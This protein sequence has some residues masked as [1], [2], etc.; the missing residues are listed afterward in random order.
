M[1]NIA[2][3][4]IL[5][6]K[7]RFLL[8]GFAVVLG[9]A[10]MA[11]TLVLTDTI[12]K[13]F[14]DLFAEANEGT[15]AFVRGRSD[16]EDQFGAA[17]RGQI[18]A[19]LVDEIRQIPGVAGAEGQ[20]Q[21]FALI[22]GAD[23]E[24]VGSAMGA[25]PLG[26]AWNYNSDL[27]PLELVEG[28]PPGLRDD[29]VIDKATA[30]AEGFEV[31]DTIRILTESGSA[32]YRVS[33]IARFG[34]SDS[35]AGATLAVFAPETAQRVF[36]SEGL[37]DAVGVV[38]ED[39]V[40][41][42]QLADDLRLSLA[43]QGADLEVITG[44]QLAEETANDIEQGLSF[45]NIFLLVFAIVALI[46]G[47]FVIYNS[48]SITV[49]QR[50]RENALLRA[51]G[52]SQR[53]VLGAVLIEAFAVGLVASLLGLGLGIIL[54]V[55]L[56]ALLA[57]F[58]FDLPASDLVVKPQTVIISVVV[59]LFVSL[60][61]ALLPARRAASVPPL[62]A[63]R[64]V[65]ST[66]LGHVGARLASALVLVVAGGALLVHGL[67]NGPDYA[68]AW[69]GIGALLVL[70]AVST[71][72]PLVAAPLAGFFGA[73]LPA[74][75]GVTGTIARQN[76]VRNPMRTS[77]TAAALMV[78][79]ALVGA[80]TIFAASAR[81]SITEAVATSLTADYVVDSGT[82][83]FGGLSPE[84][85]RS[86]AEIDGVAA[87]SGVRFGSFELDGKGKSLSAADPATS[88]Q[89]FDVSFV[90]GGFE[91]LGDDGL[92]IHESVAS[93]EGWQIGDEVE[94]K[95]PNGPGTLRIAGIF[96]KSD[97]TGDY[98]VGLDAYERF[99]PS[100]F[101][102]LVAIKLAE[103]ADPAPVEQAIT[104]ELEAFPAAELRTA[105]EYGSAQ[106]DQISQF[107]NL[108]Y[109]LLLLAVVIALFGIATALSLSIYERTHE[110]GLLR[111]VG[112]SRS[113]LR[114]SIRW[115]SV[116]IALLG[117]TLGIAIGVVFAWVIV[118]ALEDEGFNTFRLPVVGLL[119]VVLGGAI[120]GV[121]SAVLPA[122]RASRLDVLQS[123][124]TE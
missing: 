116:I 54:A 68:V 66:R 18:P 65:S 67:F 47:A 43:A 38:A 69:V 110:I 20:I 17:Q 101:D 78:G 23:G 85:A 82:F 70:L 91:D 9:V 62:A 25:P 26:F 13:V 80:V 39:G 105:D 42:E 89:L 44:A 86:V 28:G 107:L 14:D 74:L 55:G 33:G 122:R 48:F 104:A 27:N 40:S 76:A 16:F 100:Q 119:V 5:G 112:M 77:R 58:G 37:L 52:A 1:W 81:A 29:V 41:Q 115:E 61:A 113:Q 4:S 123:I 19:S 32:E 124:A 79:V 63:L 93:A 111:A 88:A 24:R 83:G 99:F 53:Q 8:T 45:F 49:A 84:F 21:D 121:L 7:R 3:Q 73:P 12:R 96:E 92:A 35:A 30:D 36:K 59:G 6:R 46:V 15:D 57:G 117:T 31:G 56:K 22:I 109:A 108:I 90:E 50:Q 64:D 51:I 34:S 72:G 95:F 106:A 102:V 10:F 2:L 114:E 97:L 71:L 118:K 60:V 120:A 94:A 103:G 98:L 87:V 11:G 75:R